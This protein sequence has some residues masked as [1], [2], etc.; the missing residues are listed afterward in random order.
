MSV[1]ERLA[2]ELTD[3]EVEPLYAAAD[4]AL[5]LDALDAG[6]GATELAASIGILLCCSCCVACC[7]CCCS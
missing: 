6:H 3:L 2:L 5:S 7:C 1:A 4:G